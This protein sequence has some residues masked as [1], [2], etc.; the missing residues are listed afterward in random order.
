MLNKKVQDALNKQ[1]NAELYSSYLYLAMQ[2]YFEGNNLAGCAH[3]MKLQSDEERGHALKIFDFVYDRQ[4]TVA[5]S[6]IQQPSSNYKSPLDVF[7]KAYEHEKT[8]SNMIHRL[9][10]LAV[11][12]NDYPTQVMLNW[13]VNEQVE[14][15]KQAL[16]IVEQLKMI[17]DSSPALL[18]LDHQLGERK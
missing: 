6:A 10:D 17:G 18:Y 7:Q 4:G 16:L 2:A 5:L 11:K 15:E 8:V 14:E 1:I 13:F 9:Y 3:W 12:E